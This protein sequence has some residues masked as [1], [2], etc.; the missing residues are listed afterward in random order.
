MFEKMQKIHKNKDGASTISMTIGVFIFLIVLMFGAEVMRLSINFAVISQVTTEIARIGS[1]QGGFNSSP[2]PNYPG[3]Y[4]TIQDLDGIITRKFNAAKIDSNDFV[5]HIGSGR[6]GANGVRGTGKI[7]YKEEFE[8]E[9]L[10]D[11]EWYLMGSI[12]GGNYEQQL[13]SSRMGMSEWKYD[14]SKW[15]GE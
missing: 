10:V 1:V 5:I 14:Y 2:P 12:L 8:V 9:S 13:R 6:I 3:K 4:I 7:D 15:D 11:Y